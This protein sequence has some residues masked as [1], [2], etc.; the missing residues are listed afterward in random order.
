M[1]TRGPNLSYLPSAEPEINPHEGTVSCDQEGN[2]RSGV[3]LAMRDRLRGLKRQR[4]PILVTER[5]ARS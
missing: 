1:I 2:R 5:W 3:A 4:Y